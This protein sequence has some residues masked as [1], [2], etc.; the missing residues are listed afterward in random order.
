MIIVDSIA[1]YETLSTIKNFCKNHDECKGCLY[2]L[3]VAA[4]LIKIL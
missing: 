4:F 3:Y 2:Q 1:E